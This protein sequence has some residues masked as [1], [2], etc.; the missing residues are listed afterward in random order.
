MFASI[1]SLLVV[2]VPWCKSPK[3]YCINALFSLISL[4]SAIIYL[5]AMLTNPNF[6]MIMHT[7]WGDDFGHY[8][9]SEVVYP[10]MIEFGFSVRVSNLQTG[11]MLISFAIYGLKQPSSD[12]ASL[13]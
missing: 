4:I 12:Y 3:F 11:I 5:I 10:V 1:C 6:K 8:Y 9:Q 13:Y 7:P 2:L